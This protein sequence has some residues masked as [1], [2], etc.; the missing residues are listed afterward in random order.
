MT[1]CAAV[2]V[3]CNASTVTSQRELAYLTP[4]A[5]A[6]TGNGLLIADSPADAAS[7]VAAL[8]GQPGL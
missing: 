4:I 6:Y 5:P 2:T 7:A 3:A 1:S 8:A